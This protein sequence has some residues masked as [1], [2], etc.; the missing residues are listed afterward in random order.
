MTEMAATL[1]KSNIA[2]FLQTPSTGNITAAARVVMDVGKDAATEKM[3]KIGRRLLC[4]G[5]AATVLG[6]FCL[7]SACDRSANTDDPA[8]APATQ[9]LAWNG[10]KD[11]DTLD[12]LK[13]FVRECHNKSDSETDKCEKSIEKSRFL[14]NNLRKPCRLDNQIINI[15]DR[16]DAYS[17]N[18]NYFNKKSDLNQEE[19]EDVKKERKGASKSSRSVCRVSCENISKKRLCRLLWYCSWY[20]H[21]VVRKCQRNS[22]VYIDPNSFQYN[23]KTMWDVDK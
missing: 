20:H 12:E 18:K 14:R 23:G 17:K 16:D 6:F 10:K 2:G 5:S 11:I 9:Q 3:M 22:R 8:E 15:F 19:E 7:V 4:L 21:R 1:A 13:R